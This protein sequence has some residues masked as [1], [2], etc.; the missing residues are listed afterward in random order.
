M[1]ILTFIGAFC[2]T[3][4]FTLAQSSIVGKWKTVDDN[5]GDPR[6]IVEILERNGKIY[7]KI[8]KL[9]PKPNEDPDPVCD[10]CNPEDARYNK[11]VI[12][13]E[14]I[15][16]MSKEEEEYSAGN[17]LDPEVGKIYRCKIWLENE[18]LKVRGYIGPFFRTQTWLKHNE[19]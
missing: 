14:I 11:K 18:E 16:E 4:L 5:S 3:A 13:M 17:I 19:Q 1:K 15:R 9:F 2:L 8:I 7:G 6:S 10:K 12:G